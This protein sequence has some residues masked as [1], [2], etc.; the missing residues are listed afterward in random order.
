MH[1][2]ASNIYPGQVAHTVRQRINRGGERVWRLDD[3][4]DMPFMAVAK[5]LSRLAKQGAIERLSKGVYF[6]G[7]NTT[8]GKSKPNSS[9]VQ[10]LASRR[11]TVFPAGIAAAN[12]LGFSTQTTRHGE[13]STSALSLPRKLVGKDTIIHTRRP[14]AWRELS[15]RDAALLDFLRRRGST[16]ELSPEETV[17]RLLSILS[18]DACLER[19]LK[20]AA[21]EPPRVRAMLGA[22]AEQ[23]GKSPKSLDRLHDSLNP[24]SRFDFGALTGLTH[25]RRW[26][27]QE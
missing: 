10:K 21:S 1:T 17:K 16:S 4:S 11:S 6:R 15:D 14:A 27:A 12:A 5:A 18:K 7:R 3:F 24:F 2:D 20:V 26:Q 9:A 23:L 13:I 22:I 19:L 8:F 25:A